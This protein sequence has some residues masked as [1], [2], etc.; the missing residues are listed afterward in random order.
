MEEI[1][2]RCIRETSC[3]NG[4]A[5]E[6]IHIFL[7]MIV[8]ELSLGHSV[9]LGEEVGEFS[10]RLRESHLADNSPR[11]PKESRYKVVFRE[12]SGMKKRL[13]QPVK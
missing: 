11:T 12:G 9:D 3:A 1:L 4:E 10:V 6:I 7:E 13:K 8:E 2:E 5:E